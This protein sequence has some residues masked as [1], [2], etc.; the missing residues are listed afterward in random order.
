MAQIDYINYLPNL[1]TAILLLISLYI[2][3]SLN[4]IPVIYKVLR[5]RKKYIENFKKDV[6][7]N[8]YKLVI[9]F[10]IINQ[11]NKLYINYMSKLCIVL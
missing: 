9:I 5:L 10:H 11:K 4:Y 3:I 1:L 6:D 7:I 2:F 8:Y